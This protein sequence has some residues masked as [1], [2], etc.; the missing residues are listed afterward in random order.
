MRPANDGTTHLRYA[1][2]TV[3]GQRVAY[4]VAGSGEPVVLLH[5]LAGSMRWWR[6]NITALA[7]SHTVYLPHLPGFGSF[8]RRGHRFALAEAADWLGE[9]IDAA[10]ITPCH[11]VAHSMGGHV[12]I[13][14]AARQPGLVRRLVLVAPALIAGR[15]SLLAYPWA[16][17]RAGCAMSPSFLP[18]LVLDILRAGPVTILRA[19]RSLLAE[20]VQQELRDVVAPTLLVWGERD[21]L[22]PPSVG[23]LMQAELADARL[24]LLP[25][26]G[27]VPQFDRPPPFNAATLAF[28]A[29]R[30]VG[31]APPHESQSR[32]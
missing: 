15:R 9:W 28:L 23:A 14:L 3:Q 13:R 21:F 31:D 12:A 17:A 27:H 2:A 30:T 29:G 25:G 5:G 8:R 24:L 10:A 32:V 22:V 11:I 6:R 18:L 7:K 19:A 26:A 1:E 16:L 4:H 20:D